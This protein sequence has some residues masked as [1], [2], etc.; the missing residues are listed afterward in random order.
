MTKADPGAPGLTIK[1]RVTDAETGQPIIGA[2]VGDNKEYN[3]GKL[4]A[5]TDSNG[6][7]EYKTWYEEHTVKAEANGYKIETAGLQTDG[8]DLHRKGLFNR[9]KDSH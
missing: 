4:Y 5:V 1:G 6:N 3:E 2:K 7:Y 8:S 9:G